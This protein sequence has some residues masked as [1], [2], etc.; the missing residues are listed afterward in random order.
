MTVCN[1]PTKAKSLVDNTI[2]RSRP[3]NSTHLYSRDDG[4]GQK[5]E[6]EGVHR[7]SVSLKRRRSESALAQVEADECDE[8]SG[9]P[10]EMG[11]GGRGMGGVA[12]GKR[13]SVG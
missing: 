5:E 4:C 7:S 10:G 1:R 12:C 11:C 6:R 13:S 2:P 9:C 3:S 8:V